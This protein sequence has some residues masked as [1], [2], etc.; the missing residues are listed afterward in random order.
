MRSSGCEASALAL[1]QLWK[2]EDTDLILLVDA[3]NAFNRMNREQALRTV[4][5]RC[6]V[7]SVALRNL[8]GHPARLIMENGVSLLRGRHVRWEWRCSPSPPSP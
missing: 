7:M 1:Q 5:Q 3:S 2:S 6:P 8:Y 4:G